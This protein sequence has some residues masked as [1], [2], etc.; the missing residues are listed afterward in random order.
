M[1]KKKDLKNNGVK[2]FPKSNH[3]SNRMAAFCH[4]FFVDIL[5]GQICMAYL[6]PKKQRIFSHFFGQ[7]SKMGLIRKIKTINFTN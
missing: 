1:T 7:V 5:K 3:H 6:T 4:Y 2:A